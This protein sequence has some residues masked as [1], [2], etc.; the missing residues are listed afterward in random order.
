MRNARAVLA[1][2]GAPDR[3]VFN[4]DRLHVCMKCDFQKL[5]FLLAFQEAWP[6]WFG[7]NMSFQVSCK[8][9]VHKENTIS[10][11][12]MEKNSKSLWQRITGFYWQLFTTDYL[13]EQIIVCW[14][15]IISG[16][17]SA[18]ASAATAAT[19]I[20]LPAVCP[21]TARDADA[22]VH[23]SGTILRY[24]VIH[25]ESHCQVTSYSEED[26]LTY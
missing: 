25:I 12:C 16:V 21:T 2:S 7:G 22:A 23:V 4:D 5:W 24:V 1:S 11:F 18:S 20:L 13:T 14:Q 8:R 17:I 10:Q 19:I 26:V 15:C 3:P 9:C 6:L